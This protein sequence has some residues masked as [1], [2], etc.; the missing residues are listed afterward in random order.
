MIIRSELRQPGSLFS[1]EQ[2]YN[3]TVTRH[4]FV[5]TFFFVIPILIGGFGN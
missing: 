2:L 5:I 1:D 3:V 4:A